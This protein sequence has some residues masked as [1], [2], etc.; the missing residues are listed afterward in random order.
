MFVRGER[1]E[2][3]LELLS[4]SAAVGFTFTIYSSLCVGAE[5]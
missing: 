1:Q 2:N 3:G 4:L 5:A